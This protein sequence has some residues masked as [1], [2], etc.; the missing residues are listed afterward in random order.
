[1][2]RR[3]AVAAVVIAGGSVV[4]ACGSRGKAGL[5]SDGATRETHLAAPYRDGDDESV[6]AYGHEAGPSDARAVTKLIERYY[7]AAAA[8]D[9]RT[10]CALTAPGLGQTITAHYEEELGSN[11]PAGLAAAMRGVNDCGSA[12]T[13]LFRLLHAEL[14][15]AV[16]VTGVRLQGSYGYGLIGSPTL[17][18]SF[19]AVGREGASWKIDGLLGRSVP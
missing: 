19:I 4:V 8:G 9:G 14:A 3:L 13:A 15:A 11:A 5:A 1:M 17:P 7:A 10:A 18:A 12:L 6:L 16:S 2:R